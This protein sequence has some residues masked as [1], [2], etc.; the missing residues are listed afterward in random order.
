MNNPSEQ[1]ARAATV[2]ARASVAPESNLAVLSQQEVVALCN[3]STH[4]MHEL[5]RR[6]ALAVLSSGEEADDARALLERYRDFVVTLEQED[7]GL[8]LDLR[9]APAHAFVDGQMIH[10]VR[11]HLFAVLRDIVYNTQELEQGAQFD[12]GSAPGI[13]DAVFK[14]LRHAGLFVPA[15]D[16]GLVVCW[17]GHAIDRREYDYSK[18]VGYALGLRGLD[19]CTGCGPGAMK[20]PMKGATIGHA[21]QRLA[22]GRYIGITEPGIIAAEAPNPIVNALVI[23]PDMEKRLEAFVRLA[24]GIVIF[25]GGVGTA[26]EI[27][28]LLGLLAHPDNVHQPLPLVLTGPKESA[29]YFE[30]LDEFIRLVLG[31]QSASRYRIIIDD[32]HGVAQVQAFAVRDVFEYRDDNDDASYFNWGLNVLADYQ[33]PF[34][35]THAAMSTLEISRR[36]P[37]HE[38]A[39]NLRRVFS[40]L[41]AGNV[42]EDGI[43]AVEA[44]GPFQITGDRDIMQALD[45][46]LSRFVDQQRMRLAGRSY[47]PCYELAS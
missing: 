37:P 16:R 12:L 19:I 27:L 10:G 5:F 7:R 23:M 24:H 17:G 15:N 4:A 28:Y 21:K 29:A 26:E 14:I 18:E 34:A 25:P 38:L 20:G 3:R 22:G 9:N 8:R 32:P 39:S 36:L 35:A 33:A 42:K 41:V 13:T 2:V 1:A 31:A 40:G 6:C 46:L 11:E 44:H 30:S 45:G 47:Q 43:A